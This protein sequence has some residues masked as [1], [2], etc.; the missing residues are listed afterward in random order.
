MRS[1]II[2][3]LF[4][5][6]LLLLGFNQLKASH[7]A[8]GE[9]TYEHVSGNNYKFTLKIS[10]F[11]S[12]F[13]GNP[14][15][16]DLNVA[17]GLGTTTLKNSCNATVLTSAN[18]VAV[19]TILVTPIC[20]GSL[21][22]CNGGTV[23]G[24]E[25]YV[26]EQTVTLN[27]QCDA[28]KMS[29][30]YNAR[31][32]SDNLQ[33]NGALYIETSLNTLTDNSNSSPVFTSLP[34]PALCV[35][36]TVT[37][38]Y[39]AVD[40][41][42]D[43]LTFD[44]ADARSNESSTLLYSTNVT[45]PLSGMS[46]NTSTG[47]LSF[48]APNNDGEYTVVVLCK[49]YDR[50]TKKLLGTVMRDIQF[51][52]D[53]C[54]GNDE[55]SVSTGGILT[56]VNGGARK[57]SLTVI[58]KAGSSLCFK[59]PFIDT[60]ASDTLTVTTNAGTALSG[61]VTTSSSGVNPDTVEICWSVPASASGTF[62]VSIDAKD[63]ACPLNA[64]VSVTAQIEIE[65]DLNFA[66]ITYVK[67]TCD[68][69]GDGQLTAIHTG[70]IGPFS[71]RWDSAGVAISDTTKTITNVPTGVVYGVYVVDLFDMD[72]LYGGT[73]NLP[74]TLPVYVSG[75]TSVNPVGCAGG[76]TGSIT[77][78]SVTG[79][80]VGTGGYNY[81]WSPSGAT[82]KNPTNL[83]AGQHL[84]TISDD[85]GCDSSFVF[86]IAQSP[87]VSVDI[88][89]SSMVSCKGGN[90]GSA[91]A[92]AF[93]TAC[94]IYGTSNPKCPTTTDAT[95]G[96]GTGT[97]TFNTYPAPIGQL[98]NS[99]QQYLYLASEIQAQGLSAGRIS[100][101][102]FETGAQPIFSGLSNYE[103][104]IGCT[105]STDLDSGFVSGLFKVF[106]QSNY[107]FNPF[108]SEITFTFDQE[109]V[110][111]GNSNIVVQICY[112]K[113]T[114]GFPSNASTKLTTTA[115][116]STAM[117]NSATEEA[118][119]EDSANVISK[120]RPNATF[121]YCDA[122]ISYSWNSNPIQTDS[123]ASNLVA[124]TYIVTATNLVGCDAKDTVVI[125]EPA[126]GIVLS[127]TVVNDLDCKGDTN[128][129]ISVEVTGGTLAYGFDWFNVPGVLTSPDSVATNLRGGT[130]YQVAVVDGNTC[131]D[132]IDVQL[133]EP[134]GIT[135]GT[136]TQ[137]DVL[138]KGLSTGSITVVPSGGTGPY[139][140]TYTWNPNVSTTSTATLLAAGSYS[141]TATD[142]N[143]CTNDTTFIITEPTN[144]ITFGTSTQVD[145]L[146]KGLSTGSITVVPSGGTNPFSPTYTWNPNVSTTSSATLLAA[147]SYSVTATDANGCPG[148]T[149]FTITEPA[150]TTTFGG[151]S[152]IDVLCKGASTG[153]ITV[154]PS[155]G[156]LPY[157]AAYTWSPNVSTTST[158]TLLAAGSYSVTATDA[159]GCES[160]TT[161]VISEPA[162]TTNFGGS[163]QIDVLCKGLSTG[164]ITVVPSGGALPYSA[165]Y[166]WNPN[167]STT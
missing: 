59:M 137:V 21:T 132:T 146:C 77:L 49:E 14:T 60:D 112:D 27:P 111:D 148:D 151:S 120:D 23:K 105:D 125:T 110:W 78:G 88:V 69:L 98:N 104:S 75:A 143:G 39:G 82:N 15:A 48:T 96:A 126:L 149:T 35:A 95:I 102:S 47:D 147:G 140:P 62:N 40:P 56:D 83:C 64:S 156:V 52:V 63:D 24:I 13:A 37:Y 124:N 152:Q 71:Y 36:Q 81:I 108:L 159:N 7:I 109:F 155:G 162:T 25:Q 66:D 46:I 116:N 9:L 122:G 34:S 90:D 41:D 67:E 114:A 42:G 1:F 22:S 97:N 28:W 43:S 87:S 30:R 5:L 107:S 165:T 55:P 99:K 45:L 70:G 93:T 103:I 10:F 61:I 65:G 106:S 160:D 127:S 50:T 157:S 12:G 18:W 44:F 73:E 17:G 86:T 139:S 141:V 3:L 167:V 163:S 26:F 136:S 31:N 53:F 57:D 6:P 134:S 117:F 38:S 94:G 119:L 68:G 118:C 54:V 138:C 158:A 76:C 164:S 150:T 4:I 121:K 51:A 161:F 84:V 58:T 123:I 92:R 166:T 16:A 133:T 100:K 128:G 33:S 142:A 74:A 144:G 80:N 89:D 29:V 20:T 8:G 11:C 19:D 91:K 130:L 153:S 145:V 135:F 154:V 101:L 72:S 2:R 79:G 32:P 131:K 85:N 129:S 115:F 113:Q